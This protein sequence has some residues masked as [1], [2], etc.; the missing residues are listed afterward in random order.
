MEIKYNIYH[1][2]PNKY[3]TNVEYTNSK[4]ISDDVNILVTSYIIMSRY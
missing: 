4:N 2:D 1:I 3:D